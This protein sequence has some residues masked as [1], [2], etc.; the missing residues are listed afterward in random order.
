MLVNA[1]TDRPIRSLTN[2]TR[3]SKTTIKTKNWTIQAITNYNVSDNGQVVFVYN[4]GWSQYTDAKAPYAI[5][6]DDGLG[7]YFP[8]IVDP[9][10]LTVTATPYYIPA[11]ESLVR[12]G[13]S[14]IVTFL[15]LGTGI[16]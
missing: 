6:G 9:G 10:T 16:D 14:R 4:S 5:A 13:A 15:A 3:F 8:W 7:D 1:D 2:G 12:K 11:G